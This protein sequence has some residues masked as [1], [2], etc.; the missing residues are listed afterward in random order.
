[1]VGR[2]GKVRLALR[3]AALA[4]LATVV[5]LVRAG[6]LEDAASAHE[7][8]DDVAAVHLLLPLAEGGDGFAQFA[9]GFIYDTANGMPRDDAAAAKWYR[10]AADQGVAGAQYNLG[11]MY[12]DGHGVPRD[13]V[14]AYKWLSIVADGSAAARDRDAA[15]KMRDVVAMRMTPEQVA[16]AQKL[17]RE[18]EHK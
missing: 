7:R 5:V 17:A 15:L 3:H 1:M 2:P 10:K 6:P 12:A 8:G 13:Y 18:W 16:Q 9:L 4:T 11:A 14:E